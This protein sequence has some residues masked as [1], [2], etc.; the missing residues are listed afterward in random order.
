MDNKSKSTTAAHVFKDYFKK[1]F[2]YDFDDLTYS[3]IAC[4]ILIRILIAVFI[5]FGGYHLVTNVFYY[6]KSFNQSAAVIET[7]NP[8]YTPPTPANSPTTTTQDAPVLT[9]NTFSFDGGYWKPDD[10]EAYLING[11]TVYLK[12]KS[13]RVRF[14]YN[15]PVP[16][17]KNFEL[18]FSLEG[19]NSGNFQFGRLGAWELTIGDGDMTTVTIKDFESKDVSE[20]KTELF[21]PRT[22]EPLNVGMSTG[23]YIEE[24]QNSETDIMIKI[25]INQKD[26][27]EF[28]VPLPPKWEE[29]NDVY[30]G[31]IDL[32]HDNETGIYWSDPSITQYINK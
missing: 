26:F 11:R 9:K 8:T 7:E 15:M 27:F 14:D 10:G 12:K 2:K 20:V 23:V 31:L 1:F 25:S 21:R 32:N 17:L 28:I 3:G 5:A 18:L 4:A 16:I 24:I 19:K 22:E 30:F 29:K 13:S 6:F